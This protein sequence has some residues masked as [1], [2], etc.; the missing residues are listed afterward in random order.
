VRASDGFHLHT[1]FLQEPLL[2][3]LPAQQAWPTA[4]HFRQK[5]DLQV[6]PSVHMLPLQQG[7]FST[8]HFLQ[9]P[10]LQVSCR[11][12]VLV[13]APLDASSAG[14]AGAKAAGEGS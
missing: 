4:P 1:P 9:E 10:C 8:P 2:H 14:A 13:H 7:A 11:P 6:V 3:L 12:T 5:E